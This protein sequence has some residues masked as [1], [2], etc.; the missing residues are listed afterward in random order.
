MAIIRSPDEMQT[1]RY[2]NDGTETILT[3]RLVLGE[4]VMVTRRWS[5][6]SNARGPETKHGDYEEMLFVISG[7]GTAHVGEALYTLERESMLWLEQGDAYYLEAGPDGL[8]VL[9][10]CAPA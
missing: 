3:D 9:Q 4:A 6:K 5:L 8:E 7:G 10:Y 2:G 1:N